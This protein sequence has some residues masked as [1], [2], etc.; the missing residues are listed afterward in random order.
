MASKNYRFDFYECVTRNSTPGRERSTTDIFRDLHD[1][2]SR[3]SSTV[4]ELAGRNYE[5][6][7]IAETVYG[8]KGIIGKHRENDLPH[9]AVI[10]GEEREIQLEPNENLL[11]KAHFTYHQD[12]QLLILQRNH[13]C[14]S[15]SNFSKYLTESGNVTALNP[16]I[17]TAD[18]RWLMNNKIK[19]RTA[20]IAIARPTNP[21][22]FEGVEHDFNNALIATLNGSSPAKLNLT[23]KGDGYS[24]SADKRYLDSGFKRAI[25]EMQ[26]VFDVQKCK[27]LLENEESMSTHPV[28][29]VADR[30]VFDKRIEV[31]GRYPSSSNMWAALSEARTENEEELQN[32][33]GRPDANRL[34]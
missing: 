3:Q 14:I 13:F 32:Y 27:L 2:F 26:S 30:L 9:A 1:R 12:Y 16:I 21:E 10:G 22:L 6:R 28:D 20:E 25:T 11:E 5:L 15:S 33:F 19:V 31:L 18:L 7:F 17:D 24:R 4:K 8:W 23:L 29:L 34:S